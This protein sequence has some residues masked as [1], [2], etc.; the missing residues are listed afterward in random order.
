MCWP[1]DSQGK[2]SQHP[3]NGRPGRL[4]L[5]LGALGVK[6]AL[7]LLL[8]NEKFLSP[9]AHSLV[10]IPTE[11]PQLQISDQELTLTSWSM[12]FFKINSQICPSAELS[13]QTSY[14]SPYKRTQFP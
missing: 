2:R 3:L 13:H 11:L 6:E 1:L 12:K 9:P 14:T 8:G 7:L 10:T 5:G 4:Q